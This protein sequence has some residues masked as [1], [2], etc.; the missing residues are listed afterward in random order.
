MKIVADQCVDFAIIDTLRKS[1][2]VVLDIGEFLAGADDEDVLELSNKESAVLL[3][4]DKDFG[5]LVFRLKKVNFGV[6]LV[7]LSGI[8]SELKAKIV[9]KSLKENFDKM[10]KS[11]AVIGYDRTRIKKQSE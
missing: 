7:R 3:T 9:L 10:K 1:N 5:E 8:S 6:I 2:I 11:F 4:E